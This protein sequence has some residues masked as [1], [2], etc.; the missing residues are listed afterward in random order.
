MKRLKLRSWVKAVIILVLLITFYSICLNKAVNQCVSAGNSQEY[1][2][3][4]LR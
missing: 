2:E 4:G 1:C 3:N